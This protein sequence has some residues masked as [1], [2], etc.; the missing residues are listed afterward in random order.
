M[1]EDLTMEFKQI[2]KNEYENN[3]FDITSFN[4]N[5]P[6]D[7]KLDCRFYVPFFGNTDAKIITCNINPCKSKKEPSL[8]NFLDTKKL[9]DFD[10]KYNFLSNFYDE[11][12]KNEVSFNL[13]FDRKQ[14]MFLAGFDSKIKCS[15][16]NSKGEISDNPTKEE[17][18]K[19]SLCKENQRKLFSERL[20]LELI[21]FFSNKFQCRKKDKDFY[22]KCFY[23]LLEKIKAINKNQYIILLGKVYE[24]ILN[25]IIE[26]TEDIKECRDEKFRCKI[27][28]YNEY[29]LLVAPS[30]QGRATQSYVDGYK[31]GQFCGE[32]VKE[33]LM[34]KK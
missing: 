22:E 16:L 30:F 19:F 24:D 14:L 33:S 27:Y 11:Y 26:T 1:K 28:C 5:K 7:Y 20:Q 9:K 34:V 25:M 2:I 17:L 12:Y 31:Y 18:K 15:D 23:S 21:P 8:Y 32:K 6:D 10:E 3:D 4:E 29:N 13:G